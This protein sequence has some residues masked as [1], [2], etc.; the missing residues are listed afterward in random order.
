M[1]ERNKQTEERIFKIGINTV[2]MGAAFAVLQ[3]LFPESAFV[4]NDRIVI[5]FTLTMVIY[6]LVSIYYIDLK[7]DLESVFNMIVLSLGLTNSINLML[8]SEI[9]DETI[10][11]LFDILNKLVT[12][13]SVDE[14]QE[15][16]DLLSQ[17]EETIKEDIDLDTGTSFVS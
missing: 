15:A 13:T 11:K 16:L 9:D 6:L 1:N 12:S 5:V 8:A 2:F 14:A 7:A 4:T 10:D 17:L 3:L